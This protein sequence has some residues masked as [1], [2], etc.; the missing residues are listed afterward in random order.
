MPGTTV[1]QDEVKGR[2]KPG[3]PQ[4]PG[5]MTYSGWGQGQGEARRIIDV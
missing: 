3:G 2:E 4:M 5:N 1:A